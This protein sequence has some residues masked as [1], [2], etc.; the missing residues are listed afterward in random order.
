[1]EHTRIIISDLHVGQNDDF[2]IFATPGS[3]KHA[4][5]TDF[6][7]HARAQANP[8]E[9]IINGDFVDFL[10][11]R[12]WNDLSRGTAVEKIKN[13]VTK[14]P[15]VF[16]G[17]GNFLGDSR[18]MLKILLGNHDVELAYPEVGQVLR[19]AIFPPGTN[20][21]DRYELLNRRTTYNPNV[22]GVLVSIEHGNRGDEWNWLNYT[23]L[24]RD[25][26]LGTTKFKYPAGTKLVYE[27]MNAFKEKLRFV[28]LLKPE[29]PAVLLL[30]LALKPMMALLA[31]PGAALS[32]LNSISSGLIS[33]LLQS[34]GGAPL[35]EIKE[36]KK[37][38]SVTAQLANYYAAIRPEDF[39]RPDDV[40]WFL[41]AKEPAIQSDAQVLGPVFDHVRLKF[42][43]WSLY[44]L[45]RFKAAQEGEEFYRQ[46]HPSTPDSKGAK[47]C[48][49]GEVKV[50][51]FGH[52]HE[53]LKTEFDEGLY[54]NS[55]TWADVVRMPNDDE[56]SML[57]W[58]K[59]VADNT[60]ERTAYPTYVK[61]EPA[62]PGVSVSLN[63]WT[64][65][66]EHRLWQKNI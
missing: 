43:A 66:G 40:T 64:D 30:L 26:E 47:T 5:F 49:E 54:V 22:N 28:D 39:P 18:H 52:T 9:L 57:A 19:D 51:V 25:A 23:A 24:F 60:F 33:G 8:V 11:L 41:N 10:Q 15:A 21:A 12:P 29:M 2:D 36:A 1:M 34:I 44:N 6:L 50:V 53:A 45:N 55:G 32:K 56:D 46:D 65:S 14:S 16:T 42:L 59:T 17:L 4:L 7:N 31:V 3:N 37:P 63:L 62:G 48:F 38:A 58:L 61:I 20:G 13:I 27:T 35:G